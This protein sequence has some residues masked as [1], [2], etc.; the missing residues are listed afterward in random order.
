VDLTENE[1]AAYGPLPGDLS[2]YDAELSRSAELAD[3]G[4]YPSLNGAEIA[5]AL[6]T[7]LFPGTTFSGSRS[8]ENTVFAWRS[9]DTFQG[10]G[11]LCNRQPGELFLAGGCF[12]ALDGP[13][14]PGP[15]VAKVDAT[16]GAQIW[17]T[18]LENANVSGQWIAATNLNILASGDIVA[19]WGVSV[20]LLDAATGRILRHT[21][22]PTGSTP[23]ID[24]NFKHVTVAPDGTLILKNQTRPTGNTQQG[25]L[26]MLTGVMAGLQQPNSEI[27]AV[28]PETLEVLDHVS[29]TEPATTP[30][31]ITTFDDRIAIYIAAD[32]N[33][34]RY[35]WDPK[36]GK[37]IQDE[38]WIVPYLEE[39]QCTG[40][41][42]GMMGDW[43]AIQ[44]NGLVSSVPSSVTAINQDDPSRVTSIE[45][46]GPLE[47][48]QQSWAPPKSGVDL[49]NNMLYS[50]DMGVGKVAGIRLDPDSGE[51]TARFV[52]DDTTLGFQP[53]IGAKDE[54]V[55]ILSDM[56]PA[57]PAE[58][59]LAMV[60]SGNYRERV[61]WRD[62]AT[63][64]ILA[65][66]EL[67]E[68]LTLGSLMV[69][70][71]GGR[72]YY[73]TATGFITL[74]VVPA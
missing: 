73:P 69:P 41:A 40:D 35:F 56:Q 68:P 24:S 62:A 21:T 48:G 31:T 12:P 17:R 4:Y 50:A 25:S 30:H 42:P 72:L 61:T 39:G 5:D 37:L 44:T 60:M 45:P 74:Q 3:P 46:F 63:G 57:D 18:Y 71:Y 52:V 49:E 1:K 38:D 55:L 32:V 7:G 58:T 11:F 47:E 67:G 22:L 10:T 6:R 43:I 29:M 16:T 51:M 27:V 34:Y 19:S 33:A 64:E 65:A 2:L 14:D 13:V 26:A 23:P 70:A 15:Y 66:S 9:K 53:L 28:H 20:V 54:R 59:G 36:A 8:G